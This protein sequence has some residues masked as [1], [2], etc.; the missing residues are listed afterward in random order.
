MEKKE[1]YTVD[2]LSQCPTVFC[3][4]RDDMAPTFKAKAFHN[5]DI[6]DVDLSQ[7]LNQWTILFFYSSNFT[8]V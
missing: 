4:T 7:Q 6:I 8:F 3:A 5:Q 2:K 1:A